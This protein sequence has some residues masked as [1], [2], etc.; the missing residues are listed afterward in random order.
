MPG[1]LKPIRI[2][3][4]REGDVWQAYCIDFNLAAQA[5]TAEE[6]RSIMLEMVKTYVDDALEGQDK[7]HA[8]VFLN[9]KAP[10]SIR[11]KYYWVLAKHAVYQLRRKLDFAFTD[12]LYIDTLQN[13][14]RP[15]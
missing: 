3:G 9:R 6:V 10:L 4:Y 15:A 2:F 1:K 11:L 12:M 14:H 7:A 13:N 8:D 5:D